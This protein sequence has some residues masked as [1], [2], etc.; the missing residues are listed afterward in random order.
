MMSYLTLDLGIDLIKLYS[1]PS[2]STSR[3]MEEP[4]VN[5][6]FCLVLYLKCWIGLTNNVLP[7][8]LARPDRLAFR[9]RPL[10]MVVP[11]LSSGTTT[12]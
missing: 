5:N 4:D 12:L 2:T 9:L 6:D 11:T 3:R 8:P 1:C 10:T 7:A